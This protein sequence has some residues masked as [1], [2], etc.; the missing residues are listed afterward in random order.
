MKNP[1]FALLL[2]AALAACATQEPIYAYR[3][4]VDPGRTDMARFEND[5]VA[6]RNIAIQLEAEQ[7]QRTSSQRGGNMLAGAVTGAALG[8]LLGTGSGNQGNLIKAGVA[9]GAVSG[10]VKNDDPGSMQPR[11]VVDRCM[12]QRGHVLLNDPGRG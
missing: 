8:A 9:A 10:A 3:P 4:V 5:L 6:C 1:A 2:V 12:Q 11:R 7:N